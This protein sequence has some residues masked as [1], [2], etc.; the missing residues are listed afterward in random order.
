MIGNSYPKKSI[1]LFFFSGGLG[2]SATKTAM[3]PEAT[4]KFRFLDGFKSQRADLL[5]ATPQ[6]LPVV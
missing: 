6:P 2:H 1:A 3:V 5:H 4:R